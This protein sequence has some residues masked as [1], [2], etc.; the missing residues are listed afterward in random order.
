M[1]HLGGE[2]KW[3]GSVLRSLIHDARTEGSVALIGRAE[4]E[5]ML[6]LGGEQCFFFQRHMYAQV[7]AKSADIMRAFQSDAATFTRLEGEWWTRLQGDD[8]G[9]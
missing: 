5:Q 8:F 4:P 3:L 2:E 1:L 7:H 9:S 6:A